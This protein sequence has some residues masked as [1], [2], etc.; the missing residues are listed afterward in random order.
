VALTSRCATLLVLGVN[1]LPTTTVSILID[2]DLYLL[3]VSVGGVEYELGEYPTASLCGAAM[4]R[5]LRG[6]GLTTALGS[7]RRLAAALGSCCVTFEV[8]RAQ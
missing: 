1:A 3:S 5:W 8:E 2:H 7:G 4:V 6:R